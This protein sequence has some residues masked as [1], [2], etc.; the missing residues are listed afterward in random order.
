QLLDVKIKNS[1][2]I[3][4]LLTEKTRIQKSRHDNELRN[5]KLDPVTLLELKAQIAAEKLDRIYYKYE[6]DQV[7]YQLI[8]LAGMTRP[9]DFS[10]H[11]S[12][13]RDMARNGYTEAIWLWNTAEVLN[14][15]PR[16]AFIN[17]CKNQGV[18][19][20]F[21]SINKKVI[22][23][24]AQSSDLQTFIAHLHYANIK[25]AALMG[26]PIWVYKKNRQKM[27]RRIR[28]VLEYNNNTIDPARFDAIHLDIEPHTLAEWG[29]YKKFLVNNLAETLKLANNITSRGRQ[30]LPLEI[31]I[32]TFY[33]KVDKTA[34]KKLFRTWML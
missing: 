3:L 20:V 19:K 5:L 29:D 15:E 8:Y 18:N 6:Q 9:E 21:V 12:K 34:W 11:L 24:I 1:N 10:Y 2:D 16:E 7:Y 13:D 23:S 27:L 14:G 28:F 32:P 17:F 33:H 31:D 22:S 30:R 4:D 25:A 26:E